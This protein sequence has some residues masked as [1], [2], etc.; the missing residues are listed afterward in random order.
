LISVVEHERPRRFEKARTLPRLGCAGQIALPRPISVIL[1]TR[2][3]AWRGE[4]GV[5][6]TAAAGC[7]LAG[8]KL[9]RLGLDRS[10]QRLL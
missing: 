1:E 4:Q 5:E 6:N 7:E 10:R 9:I 2:P 8:C 3:T